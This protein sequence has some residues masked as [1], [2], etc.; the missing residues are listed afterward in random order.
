MCWR[1]PRSSDRTALAFTRHLPRTDLR[2][3]T[4]QEARRCSPGVSLDFT[5]PAR[6]RGPRGRDTGL[7]E[8]P[9]RRRCPGVRA[10]SHGGRANRRRRG[11]HDAPWRTHQSRARRVLRGARFRGW[12]PSTRAPATTASRCSRATTPICL[13]QSVARTRTSGAPIDGI[14]Y[15]CSTVTRVTV[16]ARKADRVPERRLRALVEI[17]AHQ[18]VLHRFVGTH[19]QRSTAT[20]SPSRPMS[21]ALQAESRIDWRFISCLDPSVTR[22]LPT[23]H[24]PFGT[25]QASNAETAYRRKKFARQARRGVNAAAAGPRT[26]C[27]S[28]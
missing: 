23:R 21:R 25:G 27:A 2:R 15:A 12:T 19:G 6:R 3:E 22:V 11:R 4:Q 17:V 26:S 20:T 7:S 10:A 1:N 5:L 8:R 13:I 14:S 16:Y 28:V 18:D 24:L 9:S